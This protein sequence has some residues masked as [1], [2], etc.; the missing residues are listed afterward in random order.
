MIPAVPPGHPG[1]N[2]GTVAVRE[3]ATQDGY[4]KAKKTAEEAIRAV[5]DALIAEEERAAQT[6]RYHSW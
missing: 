6:G 4:Q 1:A 3:D 2:N 5:A